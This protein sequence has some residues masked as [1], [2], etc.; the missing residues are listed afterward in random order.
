M[1]YPSGCCLF[2]KLLREHS[3]PCAADDVHAVTKGDLGGSHHRDT[4]SAATCAFKASTSAFFRS[5]YSLHR[6]A[7][8]LEAFLLT[9]GR[10][11]KLSG[12]TEKMSPPLYPV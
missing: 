3:A 6:T 1:L 7:V 8:L 2:R 11:R 9:D 5:R 10:L 12:V 4:C